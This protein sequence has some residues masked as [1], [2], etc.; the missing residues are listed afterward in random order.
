MPLLARTLTVCLLGTTRPQSYYHAHTGSY[1]S[2]NRGGASRHHT[3]P[4]A[5]PDP[6]PFVHHQQ[7]HYAGPAVPPPR[8]PPGCQLDYV[9]LTGE[10]CLPAVRTECEEEAGGARLELGGQQDRCRTTVR[11]VCTERLEVRDT[12]VCA[13][14]VALVT[15]QAEAKLAEAEW[16]TECREEDYTRI[17]DEVPVLVAA[18][19]PVTLRLPKVEKTC[20]LRQTLLPRLE[21]VRVEEQQCGPAPPAARPAPPAHLTRCRAKLEPG[22]CGE[23]RLQLPRQSC[24]AKLQTRAYTG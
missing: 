24:Q 2:V 19:R 9:E 23:A 8:P 3:N 13:R 14:T 4:P 22:Q 6:A 10:V 11:T 15:V 7:P 17:C 20:L 18:V 12:E 16:R 1:T 5:R 21:C